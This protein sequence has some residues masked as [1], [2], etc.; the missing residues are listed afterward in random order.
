MKR[1]TKNILAV[2]VTAALCAPMAAMATNG[3]FAHGYGT[4][5]KGLAGG[6]AA[7]PQDSMIAATNPAGMVFV[8]NRLDVGAAIFSPNPR[9]YTSSGPAATA[10]GPGGCPFSIGPQSVDSE[11]GVFLIPHFGRNWMLDANSSIGVSVYGNGGMNTEYKGGTATYFDGAAFVSPSG[12]Y[13]AGKTGVNLEQ[14]FIAGTYAR[15]IND[16]ASWGVTPIIVY[17]RFEATGVGSFAPFSSDPTKLSNNGVDTST[18]YGLKLGIQGEAAPGVTLAA[19]YQSKM[20]MSELKDYAGL[21]AEGGDFDIP[22]TATLG[23][24]WKTSPSTVLT[25]DIQKI[26]YSAINSIANPIANLTGSCTPSPTGGLPTGSGCLGESGGAGFG[27]EDMTILKLGYQWAGSAGWTW[28]A[29]LSKGD[30]P[31]PKEETMFNILAPAVMETHLTFGFTKE[32]GADNEFNFA[33]MYAPNSSVKGTNP[34]NTAQTIELEMSQWEL[35][36]S[37]AVKF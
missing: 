14:L 6:G 17:Q 4:K 9:S 16:N 26:Y 10:C 36:G 15:K 35:E 27:W 1:T 37:W 30:Q 7:L 28:R 21:F 23:V 5:N 13:G 18:G 11:D 29:G 32:V 25:A 22:A 31:I 3:Y 12:T 20:S 19:S 2:A 34:L 8:G 33:A 24:A